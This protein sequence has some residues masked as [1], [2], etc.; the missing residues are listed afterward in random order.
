MMIGKNLLQSETASS[1]EADSH[2]MVS[3]RPVALARIAGANA[4]TT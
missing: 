3:A 4:T 1:A 2:R